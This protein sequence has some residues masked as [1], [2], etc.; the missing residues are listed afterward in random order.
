M[1]VKTAFLSGPLK[2]EVYVAQPDG[3]V[4][5]GHPKKVYRLWKALYGLKQ[6][7]RAWYNKLSKFLT[8]KE[9]LHKHG[10][11]KGQSIGT[12][13]ATK[14][15][16]DTDLSGNP[17]DQTDYCSKIGSLMYLTSSR[18]DIVQAGSS[19]E[20]AAFLDAGHAGCIDSRKKAEYAVLSTRCAQVINEYQLADM[21]TKSL[22][23]D[24]YKYLVRRIGMRCLTPAELEV[25][26]NESA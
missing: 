5:P 8:S 9:I 4:D 2:K 7:P 13:M 12:P 18:P 21:F 23:E 10:M 26:A 1:D 22:P 6:A 17:V 14:P 19:F 15:K 24:R 3:F 16:L 11:D 20:I 25:L